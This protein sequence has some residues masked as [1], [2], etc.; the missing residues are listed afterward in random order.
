MTASIHTQHPVRVETP[1]YRMGR[2]FFRAS[3]SSFHSGLF[4]GAQSTR[5]SPLSVRAWLSLGFVP[6][7]ATIL[8]GVRC[9]PGGGIFESAGGKLSV[10]KEPSRLERGDSSPSFGIASKLFDGAV[11]ALLERSPGPHVVPL[12]GGL[13]SR[14][15][16]GALL[17]RVARRD[18]FTVTYGVPGS[19]DFEI[20]NEIARRTGT[21]H[22]ALDLSPPV[23]WDV[24]ELARIADLTD[25]NNSVFHPSVWTQIV[26]AFGSDV[27][28]WTGYTG[29]GVGGS[30][31]DCFPGVVSDPV[32]AFLTH[33]LGVQP[34]WKGKASVD[35]L[36]GLCASGSVLDGLVSPAESVW[37]ANHVERY[38]THHIFLRGLGYAAPFMEPDVVR[39]FCGL[40]VAM[41]ARKRFFNSWASARWPA[42]F[43]VRT[44][45]YLLDLSPAPRWRRAVARG[46]SWARRLGYRVAPDAIAHPGLSYRHYE[47]ELR[48]RG[49]REFV[50][51]LLIQLDRTDV[52]PREQW[53]PLWTRHQAG[54]RFGTVLLNGAS[55]AVVQE[56]LKAQA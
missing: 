41:R 4:E 32:A 46:A 26:D 12:S 1:P 29:D 45:D 2:V 50:H 23:R 51:A 17:E 20:G 55:L 44:K 38:T 31:S 54:E 18:I 6:G 39:F 52:W 40:P 36:R 27:T 9:L 3:D 15:I 16:L 11:G 37:F 28:Y 10:V 19:D 47:S 33:E 22:L 21:K 25:A 49:L 42:L 24:A 35:E 56:R 48:E 43:E 8:D 30:F 53:Q 13:D 14:V 5:L 34:D 7:D